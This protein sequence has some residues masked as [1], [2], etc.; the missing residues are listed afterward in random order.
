MKILKLISSLIATA[1][2]A[3][4]VGLFLG[5]FG[6]AFHYTPPTTPSD[7]A[8]WAGAVGAVVAIIAAWLGIH[9]QL[10]AKQREGHQEALNLINALAAEVNVYRIAIGD[11]RDKIDSDL[12]SIINQRL[13][14]VF[15]AMTPNFHVYASIAGRIGL[16]KS[17][18]L[19]TEV[20]ALYADLEMFFALIN[21]NSE[22]AAEIPYDGVP[23]SSLAARLEGLF[24]LIDAQT[25]SLAKR[26]ASIKTRLDQAI[27]AGE[28]I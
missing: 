7:F 13:R 10:R 25:T 2:A 8:A 23:Q 26:T 14:L 15:P 1:F 21:K 5:Y 24:P 18:S 19:R 12:E 11:I 6:A 27:A 17:A 22:Y 28:V 4:F 20:V 3:T 9:A 16:L